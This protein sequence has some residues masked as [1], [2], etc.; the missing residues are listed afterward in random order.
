MRIIVTGAAGRLGSKVSELLLAQGHS[1]TGIDVAGHSV[2]QLDVSDFA[3]TQAFITEQAPELVIH[4]AA[5]T[6]VDGCAK[7]PERAVAINGYGTQNLAVAS[8]EAG[9]AMLYI[10]SNEVFNG[11]GNRPYLEYDPTDPINPYGYSKW[12]GEQALRSLNPRHYIV[13]TAWLFAHGGRN[14]IHA[15]LNAANA[16][17]TLRVVTNE[18]ANPTYNDDLAEGVTRLIMSGRYGVYHLVN[19]GACSRYDF[20]RY[21]LDRAGYEET[22]LGRISASE[23]P[24]PSQP[25][26]YAGLTNLAGAGIGITLRPWQEAVDA[27][28]QNE[29]L[30]K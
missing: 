30:A 4:T 18:V 24:R 17:K 12:V 25:P 21:A 7:D 19:E 28:L 8:H 23:W 6:D 16:G 27:F 14:F 15:I 22:P 1:V 3:A 9:A 5:W 2:E 11:R 29:G 10:S 26:Q 20:A 13:R